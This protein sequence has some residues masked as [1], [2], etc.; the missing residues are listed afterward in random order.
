MTVKVFVHLSTLS[1]SCKTFPFH[2]RQKKKK[3]K[4]ER[5]KDHRH[6]SFMHQDTL[7]SPSVPNPSRTREINIHRW[8]QKL[9]IVKQNTGWC[10]QP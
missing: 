10:G 6:L 1:L 7:N 9:S 2:H 4:E 8:R 3:K 5:K